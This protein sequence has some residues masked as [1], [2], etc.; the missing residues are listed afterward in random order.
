M[1]IYALTKP[2]FHH[3][4]VNYAT[5]PQDQIL[6]VEPHFYNPVKS[7]AKD[8]Q[9]SVD[10]CEDKKAAQNQAAVYKNLLSTKST[11]PFMSLV[12]DLRDNTIDYYCFPWIGGLKAIVMSCYSDFVEEFDRKRANIQRVFR[13]WVDNDYTREINHARFTLGDLFDEDAYATPEELKKVGFKIT[14]DFHNLPSTDFTVKLAEGVAEEAR[15]KEQ[16]RLAQLI[17]RPFNELAATCRQ[18]VERW[19]KGANT[20]WDDGVIE[21]LRRIIKTAPKLDMTGKLQGFTDMLELYVPMST[22]EMR[23]HLGKGANGKDKYGKLTSDGRL[24]CE[25]IANLAN[26]LDDEIDLLGAIE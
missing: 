21:K 19:N 6:M 9:A 3:K 10:L 24:I 5:K 12:S 4:Q 8:A 17:E 14:L 7:R 20:A 25:E 2:R 22:A 23:E 1:N 15:R 16:E 13:N 18:F 11:K 26:A